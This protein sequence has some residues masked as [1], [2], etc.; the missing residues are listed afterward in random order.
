MSN[1]DVPQEAARVTPPWI[2]DRLSVET[3]MHHA[4]ADDDRLSA[5]NLSRLDAYRSFLARVYGFESVVEQAI[6]RLARTERA[7]LQPRMRGELLRSDLSA[8]G[9]GE[10]A[11]ART[12]SAT[13]LHIPSLAHGLGWMFVLERQTL[14]AGLIRRQLERTIGKSLGGATRYLGACGERPGASL[15]AFGD[16]LAKLARAHAPLSMVHG[17]NEA[18]RAQHLWYAPQ[19]CIPLREPRSAVRAEAV[20]DETPAVAIAGR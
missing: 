10:S 8:L 19:P 9:V 16:M 4:A 5:L 20:A 13:G 3:A 17:A 11:L 15:R 18:F 12:P 2:F 1:R 14:L 6:L 7:W